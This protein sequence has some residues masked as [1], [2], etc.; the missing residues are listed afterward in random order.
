MN[1]VANTN[2]DEYE[3]IENNLLAFSLFKSEEDKKT[4]DIFAISSPFEYALPKLID[5][6]TSLNLANIIDINGEPLFNFI[7]K[8]LN[9]KPKVYDKKND[10]FYELDFASLS[11]KTK[12]NLE[13]GTFKVGNSKKIDSNYRAV[14]VD[15]TKN[16]VRVEDVTLKKV[17]KKSNNT[18]D[19]SR[20]DL[21]TQVQLKQIYDLLLDMKASQ[22]FQINWDRN[23]SILPPF[24]SARTKV[25]QALNTV[26]LDEKIHLLNEANTYMEDSVSAIKADLI[27]NKE[28]IIKRT[29]QVDYLYDS[30]KRHADFILN[31]TEIMTKIVGMQLY[32]DLSLNNKAMALERLTSYNGVMELLTQP[33]ITTNRGLLLNLLQKIPRINRAKWLK[34]S[35]KISLLELINSHY[36]YGKN[37]IDLFIN[38]QEKLHEANDTNNTF[39]TNLENKKLEIGDKSDVRESN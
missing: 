23:N 27:S 8:H 11:E 18:D 3:L 12:K 21:S 24:F 34:N 37:D 13:N 31:D 25:L 32:I 17:E 9:P 10:N 38:L 19:S 7:D 5:N 22:E 29:K 30:L 6:N 14:I 35:D 36:K 15:T 20:V 1:D 4:T 2:K 26:S 16:N 39:L 28:E 33:D